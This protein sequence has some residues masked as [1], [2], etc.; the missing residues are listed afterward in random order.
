MAGCTEEKKPVVVDVFSFQANYQGMQGGWFGK[1]VEDRF[2]I[3][4]NI[5]APN[6]AVGENLY[7]TRMASGNL[8]DLV[9]I[10]AERGQLE[11]AVNAGMLIDMEPFTHLMPHV[12]QYTEAIENIQTTINRS[13]GI[14]GI[15]SEVT[16]YA[17]TEPSESI[18][19]TYGP[20]LRWDLYE[21]LGYPE[22]E[23]LESLLPVL[24]QMQEEH[25]VTSAGEKTYA[26]SL[27][28][29]WDGNLMV[30][31]K[32]L[33]CFYGYDE[34]GF[35]MSKV[36][37]SA[38]ISAI[39]DD[40]PYLRALKFYF[41]ANQLGL[42]DPESRIQ[43]WEKVWQKYVDGQILFSPWP[44]LGQD[45]YNT[46]DNL[47][48]GSGF[49]FVPLNDM[50]ILSHGAITTGSPYV[51]GIG[52]RAKN[53]EILVQFIDWLYSPEGIMFNTSQTGSTGGP[54]GLTWELVDEQPR[55]TEFGKR[56][57]LEGDA[58]MSESWGGGN[59]RSGVSQLN[60]KSVLA[61]DINPNTGFSYDFRTWDSTVVNNPVYR[62]WQEKM[63]AQSTMDYLKKEN[64]LLI[65]S[66]IDYIAPAEPNDINQYRA[67]CKEVIVDY[68]W[69]MVFATN[70]DEFDNLLRQM[71]EIVLASGYEQVLERDMLIV[72]KLKEAR[73]QVA[74]Q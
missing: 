10:G 45:A 62:S 22:L 17:A 6:V 11:R 68:S 30:M 57:L 39:A 56:A 55:L 41:E 69:K 35:V 15:P 21:N 14:Y 13:E 2:N 53:P 74:T 51:I 24:Q 44:F 72:H 64:K 32:Q 7:Q 65:A 26:F 43:N 40:S 36:D 71:R 19:P 12:M 3:K 28:K 1:A 25:P 34:V 58:V 66:G 8:G 67:E 61:K 52:A 38:D 49:M 18:E 20:Y 46:A 42:V 47:N 50:E 4:L 29:D 63:K 23:T 16:S 73:D 60:F 9:M 5:I 37:G 70:K 59:W 33:S 31:A 48:A 27:F 54:E